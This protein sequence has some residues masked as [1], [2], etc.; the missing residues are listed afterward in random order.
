MKA[1][2]YDKDG[3]LLKTMETSGYTLYQ[4]KF[5]NPKQILMKNNQEGTS[6]EMQ[7]IKTTI[8][9]GLKASEFTELAM[10]NFR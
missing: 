8:N 1:M 6:T 5:W 4:D 2:F 10:R 3:A 7:S 9:S